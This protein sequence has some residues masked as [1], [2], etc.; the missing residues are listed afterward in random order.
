MSAPVAL[1]ILDGVGDRPHPDTGGRS[2]LEAATTPSL[3]RLARLGQMGSVTVVGPGIAPESDAGVFALLGYDPVHD[4]PGRG[5]LEALGVDLPLA[6]EDVA[7]RLN[8]ATA[9][10]TGL[11]L[12]SR[13]GRSLTTRE[14][15]EL[16]SALTAADL[17]A[18]EGVHAEVRATVGHRGVL[19]LRAG[20]D[21]TLSPN[22]SNADPFYE[23][24]GGMG[25]ARRPETPRILP[26]QALDGSEGAARTA[27]VLNLFLGRVGG[28]LAGHRV[29][30]RRA[31]AG[32]QI[33]N[34]LLVRNAGR[35]PS[36][37]PPS[38]EKRHRMAGAS[39]TEMP[40]E[41]GIARVLSLTD[42]YVGPMGPDRDAGYRERAR[43]AR[44]LLDRFPFVYVHLKGPDE[45]GHD[46]DAVL[47]KEI[48]EA[49]D[50]SFFAPFLEGLDLGRIR[51]GV[52]ADHATPAIVKSHTD[53]PVPLLIVGAG[54]PSTGSPTARFDEAEAV[55]GSLGPLRGSDVLGL[56]FRPTPAP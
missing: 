12:D 32:K 24:L 40:V 49:I 28:V 18:G 30:A 52:T 3:D 19:W 15:E 11:I 37:P 33:A 25:S 8:F 7:L 29:N 56:L 22:I 44:E 31:M 46:G 9:D 21:E 20:P 26:V 42:R 38:F 45:P 35:L 34:A 55:R 27:R 53:D 23:K 41:K 14:S 50:R 2:P 5:V 39:L 51:L 36:P 4:S 47:K 54:I 48:I 16:A 17:V 6:P 43:I 1:V 13:V 10:G